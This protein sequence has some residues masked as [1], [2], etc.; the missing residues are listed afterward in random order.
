MGNFS[1]P[2]AD[3]G[4]FRLPTDEERSLGFPCGPLSKSLFNGLFHRLEAELESIISFAGIT[5]DDNTNETL[6]DAVLA[7]IDSAVG[8]GDT[9]GYLLTSQARSRI[10]IFPEVDSTDGKI[11]VSQP[12]TGTVRIPAGTTFLHRGIYPVV[13]VLT[14]F[15]TNASK[16]YHLRWSYADGYALKDLSNT[17][18]NPGTLAE[19]DP[20]FDSKFDDMLIARVTTNSSNVATIT[21][22]VNKTRLFAS[23]TKD[24]T[25][26][27]YYS[28]ATATG[29][30]HT[31]DWSRTPELAIPHFQFAKGT[32]GETGAISGPQEPYTPHNL[33]RAGVRTNGHDRYSLFN[34]AYQYQ[35]SSKDSGHIKFTWGAQA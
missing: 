30:S 19:N 17:T 27:Q 13:T 32:S 23:S 3:A 14:D 20:S 28:W 5:H 6:K 1:Q 4:E 16:V 29:T 34:V 22:L 21:N 2:F 26:S 7:L 9:S 10:P 18:Y 33:I 31:L 35:D 12:A 11:T 15:T 25:A 8:G 24:F